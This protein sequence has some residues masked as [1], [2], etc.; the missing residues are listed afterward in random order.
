ME[1]NIC[2]YC[3]S[4]HPCER[5]R[6]ILGSCEAKKAA[7]GFDDACEDFKAGPQTWMCG[8]PVREKRTYASNY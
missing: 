3:E 1:R 5:H 4:Y 7:K 2:R 8:A 6:G